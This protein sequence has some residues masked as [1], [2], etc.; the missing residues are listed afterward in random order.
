MRGAIAGWLR[1]RDV[2]EIYLP[3]INR[4]DI[5]NTALLM[6][7]HVTLDDVT[8]EEFRALT[9]LR[10]ERD[11]WRDEQQKKE[12]AIAEMKRASLNSF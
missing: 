12:A 7:F 5:I 2:D 11:T 10:A 6:Q 9:I 8:P 4:I 1:G 3:L